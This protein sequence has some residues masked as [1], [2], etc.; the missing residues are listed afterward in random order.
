MSADGH[1]KRA[2]ITSCAI[3]WAIISAIGGAGACSNHTPPETGPTST[4]GTSTSTSSDP[5]ADASATGCPEL[6]EIDPWADRLGAHT[7][8]S[9]GE[10]LACAHVVTVPEAAVAQN[11]FYP[12]T[13]EP[14]ANGYDLFILQYVSEGRPGVAAAATALVYTPT[15][16]AGDLPI[17]VVDHGFYGLGPTCGPSHGSWMTDPLAIPLTGRG[18]AVIAPD[19]GGVGVDNGAASYLVGAAEAAANLDGVRALRNLHD[20]RFDAGRLGKDLF[21]VGHSQGGH[22]ALFTHQL[23]DASLGLNLLGTIAVAPAFGSARAWTTFFQNGSQPVFALESFAAGLLYAHA[24]WNGA[25]PMNAWLTPAAEVAVPKLLHDHCMPDLV[26]A[27][28]TSFA[29]VGDM[30]KPEFLAAAAGCDLSGPCPGF[31]PWASSLLAEQPGAFKSPAPT[32]IL[33]GL[34]DPL[35]LPEQ[36]ACIVDRLAAHGTPVQACGYDG[37]D[38]LTVFSDAVPAMIQWTAGRRAG[39]TPDVCAAP[40]AVTCD[41]A[42]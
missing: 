29:S 11:A 23:F 28:Y 4:L 8:A 36:T 12:P 7:L 1:L 18:H 35:V 26:S 16:Q 22:A 6:L 19:Y 30:Y 9:R 14:P 40:L 32:L 41:G 42:P 17:A 3:G 27:F 13:I 15:G 34:I 38:H 21:I 5:P 31:E 24:V 33:Q 10:I 25:P 37:D 2:A 39:T 20:A